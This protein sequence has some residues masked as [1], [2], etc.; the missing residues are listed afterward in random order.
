MSRRYQFSL[1]QVTELETLRNQTKDKNADK[2]AKA[3]LLYASGEK[4]TK[5]AEVTEFAKTYIPELVSRYRN[6]G[7]SAIAGGNYGGNHRNMSFAE[8]EALLEPFKKAAE[9]GQIV[10]VSAILAAYEE[11]LGRPAASNSQIYNVLHRHGWRK[12]MPRSKPPK[13]ASEEEIDSSKKLRIV[14]TS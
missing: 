2:R 13:S 9:A 1:E 4:T 8:E 11:K 7:I 5:I 6:F 3:L 12:L 14:S 10:E